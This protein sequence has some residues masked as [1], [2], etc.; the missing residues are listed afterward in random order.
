MKL[1]LSIALIALW[2]ISG[3][4]VQAADTENRVTVLN[5]GYVKPIEGRGF[6]PGAQD[7][8]ARKVAST[9]SLVQGKDIVLV[10]D[11]GMAAP[12]VWDTMLKQLLEKGVTPEDVTHIFISH[13]HPD[14]TTKLGLFPNATIVDFWATYKDDIWLDHPDNYEL[15][16]GIKVVRTPGHTNEDATL[17]VETS[18]GTYA[19]T[20]LWWTPGFEP[21]EDPLAEDSQ[22]LAHSRKL[23]IKDA[24]W[25]VPGH[26]S[27]FRNTEKASQDRK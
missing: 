5:S 17:M 2:A 1:K 4:V 7:D 25:I 19:L 24:D 27:L 22:A 18:E 20:H 6:V 9:I 26:G 16:P 10:A 13:H 11:P 21:K 3:T 23:I 15:A 8:G 12:G 14:H